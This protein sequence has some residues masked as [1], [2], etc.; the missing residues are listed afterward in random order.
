MRTDKLAVVLSAL[1]LV[2]AGA[3]PAASAAP[4]PNKDQCKK[5]GYAALG[6]SNQGQC[7]KAANQGTLPPPPPAYGTAT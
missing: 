3:A 2:G 1:G 5:G 7:V 4:S 6:F